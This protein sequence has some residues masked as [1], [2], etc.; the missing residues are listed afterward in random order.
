MRDLGAATIVHVVQANAVD[1]LRATG[2]DGADT[3]RRLRDALS[4]AA[5]AGSQ[6]RADAAARC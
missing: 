1:V 6:G 5:H 3:Q 4:A 2:L